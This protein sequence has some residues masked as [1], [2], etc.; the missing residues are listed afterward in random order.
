LPREQTLVSY[1]EWEDFGHKWKIDTL[2]PSE[3]LSQGAEKAEIWHNEH[4]KL[5]AKVSGTIEDSH[6]DLHPKVDVGSRW[7]LVKIKGSDE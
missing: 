7:L 2:E 1:I 5:K 4:Y 3:S 6:L